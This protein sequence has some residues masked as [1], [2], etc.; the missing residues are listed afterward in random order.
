MSAEA[1]THRRQSRGRIPAEDVVRPTNLPVPHLPVPHLP[2]LDLARV[3]TR[4]RRRAVVV[5]ACVGAGD[6]VPAARARPRAARLAQD[7]AAPASRSLGAVLV[8]LARRSV[9]P[10]GLRIAVLTG[11]LFGLLGQLVE[12]R[13]LRDGRK[14][15]SEGIEVPA[16]SA[17]HR[18]IAWLRVS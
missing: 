1:P 11:V 16:P 15:A 3:A 2:I 13:V 10:R 8:G 9:P 4:V 5:P 14:P 18:A 17:P 7:A 6:L 12:E